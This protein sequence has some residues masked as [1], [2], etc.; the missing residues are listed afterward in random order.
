MR[1]QELLVRVALL[2]VAALLMAW[3]DVVHPFRWLHIVMSFLDSSGVRK[4][5]TY[6]RE[7]VS[8]FYSE[9]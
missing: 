6:W 1:G 8:L 5:W 7:M 4:S 3:G 9:E 2:T